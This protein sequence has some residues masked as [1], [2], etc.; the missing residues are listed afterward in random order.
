[1]PYPSFNDLPENPIFDANERLI[2]TALVEFPAISK[3]FC[4]RKSSSISRMISSLP[5]FPPLLSLSLAMSFARDYQV[6]YINMLIECHLCHSPRVSVWATMT[7]AYQME[8]KSCT[9][10]STRHPKCSRQLHNLHPGKK[11]PTFFTG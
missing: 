7:T 3:Q 9:Q 4:S 8:P 5:V 11:K 6:I 2:V 10:S 1:M